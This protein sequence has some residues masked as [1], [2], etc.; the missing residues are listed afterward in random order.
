MEGNQGNRIKSDTQRR[1]MSDDEDLHGQILRFSG[2]SPV[3]GS[4][5]DN[6]QSLQ[7]HTRGHVAAAQVGQ[8]PRF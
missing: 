3:A 2:V 4:G 5:A 1:V 6:T 8:L 7:Q